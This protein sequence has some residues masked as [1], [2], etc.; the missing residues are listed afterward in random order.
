MSGRVIEARKE[1]CEFKVGTGGWMGL[2]LGEGDGWNC[3]YLLAR[4]LTKCTV[5]LLSVDSEE[6][7]QN[8]HLHY[9][10]STLVIPRHR[11]IFLE[12]IHEQIPSDF[13]CP[14][15]LIIFSVLVTRL[16]NGNDRTDRYCLPHSERFSRSQNKLAQPAAMGK[17]TKPKA[18]RTPSPIHNLTTSQ[19]PN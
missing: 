19:A 12:R 14:K 16:R 3:G 2:G 6:K 10:Y 1:K 9:I 18:K 15:F 11:L 5:L 4:L 17:I 7:N 13:P 8:I